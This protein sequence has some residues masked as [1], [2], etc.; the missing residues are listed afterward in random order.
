MSLTWFQ[1]FVNASSRS[2]QGW[3]PGCGRPE[4]GVQRL[5]GGWQHLAWRPPRGVLWL[6]WGQRSWQDHDVQNVDWRRSEDPG[7]SFPHGARPW[8]RQ[9][10]SKIWFFF[11]KLK[12]FSILLTDGKLQFTLVAC[13]VAPTSKQSDATWCNKKWLKICSEPL[14]MFW[15]VLSC[16]KSVWTNDWGLPRREKFEAAFTAKPWQIR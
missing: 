2:G 13:L 9:S 11:H 14:L 16:F 7:R 15:S 5:S 12:L 10:C 4:E 1:S 8:H 6:A 3:R